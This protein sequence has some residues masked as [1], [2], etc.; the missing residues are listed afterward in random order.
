VAILIDSDEI[1]AD[2]TKQ[3]WDLFGIESV[4]QLRKALDEMGVSVEAF[5]QT[6]A[7]LANVDHPDLRWLRE[8]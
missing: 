8:L 1:N 6:Q 2:W 7:Y 3:T 4:E 5:K